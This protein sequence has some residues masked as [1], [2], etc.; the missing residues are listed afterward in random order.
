MNHLP[1]KL[2]DLPAEEK[3]KVLQGY[4]GS[5][6]RLV[7]DVQEALSHQSEQ[8]VRGLSSRDDHLTGRR[9]SAGHDLGLQGA[10]EVL[11]GEVD[12]LTLG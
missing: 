4:C 1:A 9:Q 7:V 10:L 3:G 5:D 6:C 11:V 12:A 2:V 8:H